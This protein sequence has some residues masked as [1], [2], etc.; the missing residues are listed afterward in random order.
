MDDKK[1][2]NEELTKEI[3]TEGMAEEAQATGDL[4]R[5]SSALEF[6]DDGS[7]YKITRLQTLRLC[8]GHFVRSVSEVAVCSC[9][10][11]VCVRCSKEAGGQCVCCG[12]TLCQR[13]RVESLADPKIFYCRRCRWFGWLKRIF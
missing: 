1:Q 3:R 5:E 9:D 4:L 10:R 12:N 11:L 7:F 13:C 2:Q 6:A 8:C